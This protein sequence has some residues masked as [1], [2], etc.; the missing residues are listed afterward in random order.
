MRFL[1]G[2]NVVDE[3]WMRLFCAALAGCAAQGQYVAPDAARL[4]MTLADNAMQLLR[5][6][7]E[8]AADTLFKLTAAKLRVPG[9]AVWVPLAK[10]GAAQ[11]ALDEA[12]RALAPQEE[13]PDIFYNK[14]RA[15]GIEFL[16]EREA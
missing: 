14:L 12:W 4:A 1:Q 6:R 10:K 11:I 3:N 8:D 16:W 7:E 9:G 15:Q 13:I 2:L 5:K